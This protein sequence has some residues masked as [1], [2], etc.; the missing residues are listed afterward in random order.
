MRQGTISFFW[1]P[2]TIM[3]DLVTTSLIVIRI[4]FQIKPSLKKFGN[5]IWTA[6]Y[7]LLAQTGFC[8]NTI[9]KTIDPD[10]QLFA[11]ET[12]KL[13]ATLK[14]YASFIEHENPEEALQMIEKAIALQEKQKDVFYTKAFGYQLYKVELLLKSEKYTEAKLALQDLNNQK[15]QLKVF[16]QLGQ[17]VLSQT[18]PSTSLNVSN[19]SKGLYFL[20]VTSENIGSQTIKFIKN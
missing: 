7:N 19:L 16:N 9:F 1:K 5:G 10:K 20:N 15:V 14:F 4:M 12:H 3:Q 6:P 11:F 8:A 2:N 17:V 18:T 13:S